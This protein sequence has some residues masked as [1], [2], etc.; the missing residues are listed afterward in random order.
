MMQF[1]PAQMERYSRHTLLP[2]IGMEGQRR[3][4]AARVLLIGAGGLGSPSALYLAAA[5]VGTL[6]IVD[7]DRVELSNLQRQLLHGTSSVGR[8]KLDSARKRLNDINPDIRVIAHPVRLASSN[9]LAILED[10]DIIIDGTDNFPTRYLSNDACVLLGKPN[11]YGSVQQFEGQASVF[12][13]GRGPCYRCLFPEPPPP[14]AVPSCAEAGVL[15]ILPGMIGIIQATEAIKLIL[16]L[17]EPLVGRLL[18]YDAAAMDFRT[19][20]LRRD[21][22]CP[23]C[24]EHPTITGLI[25]YEQFCGG[26]THGTAEDT[27][28]KP[29]D[30]KRR[31]DA[32]EDIALLDVRNPHEFDAGHIPAARLLPLGEIPSR[33]G[34]LEDWRG[35][36]IVVYCQMGGRSARA[37]GILR[38]AGFERVRN[39]TGGYAKW[40]SA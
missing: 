7:D 19:I 39:L 15:G 28:M 5:G 36:E 33:L 26:G 2:Q 14:G 38:E 21:P 13:A 11:I 4:L 6:G 20:R 23:V 24:G 10:Y 31:L 16:G 17:G 18:L 30:L 32:G 25:D 1:T 27:D 29:G 40:P 8:L 22:D 37:C 12:F 35:R 34:E 3:L 9:A